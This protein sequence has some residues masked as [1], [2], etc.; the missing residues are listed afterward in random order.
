VT[1]I[2]D[3]YPV[4]DTAPD[5][6]A[7]HICEI[8]DAWIPVLIG[9]MEGLRSPENWKNPPPDITAQVEE[10]IS[11]IIEEYVPIIP[12]N[13]NYLHLHT[14]SRVTAGAAIGELINTSQELNGFWR[15]NPAALND[16]TYFEVWLDVGSYTFDINHSK[17]AAGGK[18]TIRIVGEPFTGWI[19]DFYNA[20]TLVN[21]HD[22]LAFDVTIAGKKKISMKAASKNASSSGYVLN[23]TYISIKKTG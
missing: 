23:I 11:Q 3:F 12:Y 13:T 5:E 1:L 4:P 22:I 9:Q 7:R 19:L 8:P 16:E 18:L 17:Q 2:P 15:Q 14:N 10:F 6:G 21:Q 20:A